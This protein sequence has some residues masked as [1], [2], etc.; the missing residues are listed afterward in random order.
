MKRI[1]ILI[2]LLGM[3]CGATGIAFAQTPGKARIEQSHKEGKPLVQSKSA[4]HVFGLSAF[5]S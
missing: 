2:A 4:S 1:G 5:R 3:S